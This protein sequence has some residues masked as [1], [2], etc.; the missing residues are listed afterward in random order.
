M[1]LPKNCGFIFVY[2]TLLSLGQNPISHVLAKRVR[3][4]GSAH[5]PGRL[6]RVDNYPGALISDDSKDK[7][8][9]EV[10]LLRNTKK[11]LTI[12]DRYEECSP[13][14]PKPTEFIRT[15]QK[16]YFEDG[17]AVSAWIYIFNRTTE[18]LELI[19]SGNYKTSLVNNDAKRFM[20]FYR[21]RN[22][23]PHFL[24]NIRRT[25]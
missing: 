13:S 17:R 21:S 23:S 19:E 3:F 5:F 11:L 9:G 14:F 4:I 10:Y 1:G 8:Q 16:V 15:I 20:S 6:Y 22:A 7:V 18:G 2:G 25:L 12:L 24:K